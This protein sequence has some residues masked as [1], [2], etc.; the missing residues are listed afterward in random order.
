MAGAER[1]I[2]VDWSGRVR[3]ARRAIWLAEAR[4]N[5]LVRLEDGRGR[6]EVADHLIALAE[7]E[8]SLV[9]GFDFSFSLP[10]WFL[11]ANGCSSVDDLWVTGGAARR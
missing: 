5:E 2:A 8:P 4:A 9:V 3:G 1:T 7:H 6:D 10:A 11:D